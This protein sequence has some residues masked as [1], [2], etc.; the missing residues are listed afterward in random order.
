MISKL[1]LFDSDSI[2]SNEELEVMENF[3]VRVCMP[4]SFKELIH[5]QSLMA[6]S[7][8]NNKYQNL[9]IISED[10]SA[11]YLCTED[12]ISN[13]HTYNKLKEPILKMN[14]LK[15]SCS[16]ETKVGSVVKF[17]LLDLRIVKKPSIH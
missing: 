9:M 15:Y 2:I 13:E 16:N 1:G 5:G 4:I 14:E 17:L 8:N 7:S 3:K 10:D 11:V 12:A 6:N